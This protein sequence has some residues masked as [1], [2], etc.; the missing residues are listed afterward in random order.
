MK[1]KRNK[2]GEYKYGRFKVIKVGLINLGNGTQDVWA[3]KTSGMLVVDCLPENIL[4]NYENST[5]M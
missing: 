4:K 3:Y 5:K 2:S 1:I